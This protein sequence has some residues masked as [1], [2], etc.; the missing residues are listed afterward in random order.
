MFPSLPSLTIGVY[1][2]KGASHSPSLPILLLLQPFHRDLLILL[3]NGIAH[4][5]AE[6]NN[7]IS[8]QN[9]VGS[10]DGAD[11][12][13]GSGITACDQSIDPEP[14]PMYAYGVPLGSGGRGRC[15]KCMPKGW[16]IEEL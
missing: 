16:V 11:G 7:D 10:Y 8:N 14:H 5:L 9:D 15:Q 6:S 1:L 2:Y 4:I 13:V 12:R 3:L